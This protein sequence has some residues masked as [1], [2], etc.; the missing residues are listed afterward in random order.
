MIIIF[1]AM[2]A[3]LAGFIFGFDEG[4]IAGALDLIEQQYHPTALELGFMAAAVPLGG[5][6]GALTVGNLTQIFGRKKIM[7]AASLIFIFGA[8]AAAWTPVFSVLIIARLSLGFGIGMTGVV[9]PMYISETAPSSRRGA[10]VSVFQL[11]ITIG[12]L[13]S[14]LVNLNLYRQDNWR[15]MFASGAIPGLMFLIGVLRLPE[16]PRWLVL[17][18]RIDEAKEA[19]IRIR[20][21]KD[22]VKL[23]I[24]DEVA[25]IQKNL[26]EESKSRPK[27]RELF[28]PKVKAALL[29]GV[30][31]STL[32]QLSGINIIIYFAPKIFS[33]TGFDDATTRIMAT[34]GLGTVNVLMTI[35][36]LK[37]IDLM[38]RRKL[39]MIGFAGCA[40]SLIGITFTAQILTGIWPMVSAALIMVYI[41]AFAV[42]LGPIPILMIAEIFP[43][44]LRGVG[45][46]LASMCN[47]GFNTVVVLSF[48]PMLEM[49]GLGPTFWFYAVFCLAGLYYTMRFVPETK[50]VTLEEIETH[51]S[52]DKP[53]VS[54]GRAG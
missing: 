14:Y 18:G 9:S 54:L 44:R 25:A 10:L 49:I 19:L 38:G 8:L 22:L 34:V 29:V 52:G 11:A 3:G 1:I 37:Y 45:M 24:D 30:I 31:L 40:L 5:L 16:S 28:S 48:P 32:Q 12:I 21:T 39:L 20:H 53:L 35:V 50:G 43:L 15:M 36:A 42:S 13:S 26:E 7:I 47:W 2:T 6:F 4:I 17:K 33:L 46:C 27:F 51:L 23:S 41:A